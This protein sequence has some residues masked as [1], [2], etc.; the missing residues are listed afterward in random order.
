MKM[1][2]IMSAILAAAAITGVMSGCGN[3]E[4]GNG[5][6]TLKYVMPGPGS[7]ED[8][9]K[10]WAEW[11]KKLQEKLPNVEVKFEVIPVSEYAQN[12]ALM[13]SAKEQID[14]LNTYTLNF[15]DEVH[16]GTFEPLDE[17]IDK[18]GKDILTAIPEWYMDYQKMDGVTYGIPS[19]QIAGSAPALFMIKEYADKYLDIDGFTKAF[20][21]NSTE[22][23]TAY[24]YLEEMLTKAK[25]DGVTFKTTECFWDKG[26]ESIASWFAVP[27][28]PDEEVK[29]TY[30]LLSDAKK[31]EYAM[32]RDWYKK[33]FI[34]EDE[35]SQ[36]D[37]SNYIGKKDGLPWWSTTYSPGYE[38]TLSEKYGV[39]IMAI[40]Y[41]T[42]Y[43]IPYMNSAAGTSITTLSKH[44]E[45]AMQVIN[46]L[47]TDK[48]LYN[49]LVYGIEGEHY[50]KIGEDRIETPTGQ[51]ANSSDKYGLWAWIVGN[52]E[53][54]YDLQTTS[55]GNKNWVFNEVNKSE[56]RSKLL[57]FKLDTTSISTELA[58]IEA[59]AEEFRD[60]LK[61]GS[62]ENYEEMITEWENKLEIAGGSKVQQEI[63]RQVDEFLASKK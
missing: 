45:E 18:Y 60:P 46:L 12:V 50:T 39:E 9:Q 3:G 63:Q 58:Q 47:Q 8:S 33:G 32:R 19:Y 52:A 59:I 49:L 13:L 56:W 23:E 10:V 29:V 38:K 24:G 54:A 35:L 42:G 22:M 5:K 41:Y 17:L 43:Y 2:R 6:V 16:K 1:K 57:G 53:N 30:G 14:I 21:N 11:N 51:Q 36:T 4:K 31:K 26:M 55:E 62:L 7:Q 61:S 48:E 34:R 20:Q 28:N 37:N 40:P 15:V 44:K 25:A 27:M